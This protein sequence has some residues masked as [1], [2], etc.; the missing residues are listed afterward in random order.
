MRQRFFPKTLIIALFSIL[1]INFSTH[2][3]STYLPVTAQNA[4]QLTQIERIGN[5]V[6][7]MRSLSP[8]R[9]RFAAVTTLGVWLI[10]TSGESLMLLE[11]Q[12]GVESVD[13]SPDGKMITAGGDDNSIM[14]FN[15]TTG[16]V[17]ARLTKHLYPISAVAWSNDGKLLASGDWSGIVRVWDTS[18]WSEYQVFSDAA[19]KVTS[20]RF[21]DTASQ[22]S[23]FTIDSANNAAVYIWNIVSGALITK[24]GVW[25]SPGGNH[26]T[27]GW[28]LAFAPNKDQIS[29]SQYN[30][31]VAT[32][33]G[34]Y[35][36]L[37]S[38]F[39]TADGRVGAHPLKTYIWSL[40]G[41]P[42]D[43]A[44]PVLSPNGSRL[45]TFGN[46]GVI[47][48]KDTQSSI[49][50]AALHGHIR[51]VTA[52]AFSADGK[53]LVS[54]SNDGTLQLWDATVTQD[55]GSLAT[56]TGHNGGVTSVVFNADGT[57]IASSGYDGTIR[58]WG[59]KT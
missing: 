39:F 37:G 10:P 11:G 32:Y 17:V 48:L 33:D 35:G 23:A 56:L 43:K 31:L 8:D 4:T 46:D 30:R 34:F 6:W 36:E 40:D 49:E 1:C 55:S 38:V 25:G 45:A 44:P 24:N 47:H 21:D 15:I 5:G 58:L 2:A 13:F 22:L 16:A 3:Q 54:S 20:L 14:I 59:I 42:D 27:D 52:V 18:M 12:D 26:D 7:R 51:A 50:I 53:L 41:Q 9:S 28:S 57:L 29:L 19:E